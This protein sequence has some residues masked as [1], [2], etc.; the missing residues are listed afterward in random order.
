MA[1]HPRA[2]SQVA[3]SLPG[4]EFEH[5]IRLLRSTD[6]E[7]QIVEQQRMTIDPIKF[8]RAVSYKTFVA[9]VAVST[10]EARKHLGDERLRR[11]SRIA[12]SVQLR[13]MPREYAAIRHDAAAAVGES[14]V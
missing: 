1:P 12:A 10:T 5:N 2:P 8:S 3:R 7:A 11:I 6:F 4:H 9:C 13:V 14:A